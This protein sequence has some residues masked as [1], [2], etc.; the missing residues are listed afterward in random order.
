MHESKPD[1]ILA[2]A[3]PRRR[4][5]LA[6]AGYDFHVMVAEVDEVLPAAGDPRETAATNAL[7]KARA[8]AHSLDAGIV[9]GG[10]TVVAA[11]GRIIGKP[12]DEAEARRILE[13]LS[14]TR[15]SVVSAFAL[16]DAADGRSS[17]ETDETFVRMREMSPSEIDDYV[18]SGEAMGK[19][20][21]YAIQET[22]DRFVEGLDGSL[23][24]VVGFPM[25]KFAEAFE[26]FRNSG[27]DG[28]D[29]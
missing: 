26:K 21:A 1:F 8:V 15:H 20:G 14:G 4:K 12:V 7:A 16:V 13:S 3:S 25:E 11:G 17:V 24:T 22:G 6:D 19:A 10:D 29:G 5:M 9:V 2:S 18:A 28:K 27:R 23:A